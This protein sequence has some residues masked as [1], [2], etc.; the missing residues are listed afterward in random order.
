MRRIAISRSLNLIN[1]LTA[2]QYSRR[3]DAKMPGLDG[4]LARAA[5]S[6]AEKLEARSAQAQLDSNH[7]VSLL[8]MLDHSNEIAIAT[9]SSDVI[10]LVNPMASRMLDKPIDQLLH[11]PIQTVIHN[12][13][14]RALHKKAFHST[15]PVSAQITLQNVGGG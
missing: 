7:L 2:G 5:N 10:R 9:D 8:A 13:D 14:L 15:K 6:L 4:E 11:R 3:I 12:L 1:A